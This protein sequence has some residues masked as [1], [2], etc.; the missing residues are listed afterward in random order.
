MLSMKSRTRRIKPVVAGKYML[1]MLL[2]HSKTTFVYLAVRII[3]KKQVVLKCM[4]QDDAGH[5]ETA[6]QHEYNMAN[7][8]KHD[9]VIDYVK[10]FSW[11][12]C[13]FLESEYMDAGDL[14]CLITRHGGVP[15][16]QAV[17]IIKQLIDAVH[18][19]HKLG[20][21]HRDIKPENV[22]LTST[23]NVKLG[24]MEFA[25]FWEEEHPEKNKVGTH[26]YVAPEVYLNRADCTAPPMDMWSVGVTIFV[27]VTSY[28]PFH[29]PDDMNKLRNLVLLVEYDKSLVDD[30]C[31]RDLIEKLLVARP[32][33][34]LTASMA[35]AHEWL[36]E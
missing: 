29:D 10:L 12:S 9:N 7:R 8:I 25:V 23:M 11:T 3:D 33:A 31:C 5:N 6:L 20:I 27:T 26:H 16:Q 35:L 28:F 18:Y 2:D 34:R 13:V 4:K 21:V 14:M 17:P 22:F 19:M 15:Y 30:E 1:Q 36:N 32:K 24:D